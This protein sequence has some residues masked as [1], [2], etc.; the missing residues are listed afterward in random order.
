MTHDMVRDSRKSMKIAFFI[1]LIFFLVEVAGGLL[2]GLLAL[3]SES[4]QW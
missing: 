1:T 4:H 2:S 3:I